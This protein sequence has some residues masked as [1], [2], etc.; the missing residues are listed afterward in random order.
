MK[1][2]ELE[3]QKKCLCF[4]ENAVKADIEIELNVSEKGSCFIH[5]YSILFLCGETAPVFQITGFLPVIN[6]GESIEI[7]NS[8]T[9]TKIVQEF[10]FTNE[11]HDHIL[12]KTY[13]NK[14]QFIEVT[15]KKELPFSVNFLTPFIQQILTPPVKKQVK[16]MPQR[17]MPQPPVI[18][19]DT[20]KNAPLELHFQKPKGCTGCGN[21]Q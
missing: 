10:S 2:I 7:E 8:K 16:T 21:K 18:K 12:I 5:K 19:P 13:A 15:L 6:R 9:K 11:E 17:T 3:N 1:L 4:Y 14:I 20:A